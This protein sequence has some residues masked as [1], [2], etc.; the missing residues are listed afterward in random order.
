LATGKA[1]PDECEHLT[2]DKKND[3]IYIKL[4]EILLNYSM[5]KI[6]TKTTIE[7]IMR[8]INE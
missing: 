8:L 3:I 7:M 1:Y 2:K 4:S 5:K 6:D